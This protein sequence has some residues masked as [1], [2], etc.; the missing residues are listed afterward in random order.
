MSETLSVP[1][2][3]GRVR[4]DAGSYFLALMRDEPTGFEYGEVSSS[5]Q[6]L[7]TMWREPE[8]TLEIDDQSRAEQGALQ[9]RAGALAV[10]ASYVPSPLPPT[11]I[12]AGNLAE[13]V[14]AVS[15]LTWREIADVF[16][17]SERAVAGWR[18]QGV[19]RHR[20]ETMQALRAIGATLVGGLGPRGVSEW[21]LAGSPSSRLQRVRDGEAEAVSTEALSYLDSPAT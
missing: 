3:T 10:D 4:L 8:L 12:L 21:L 5:W 9:S 7:M 16:R 1:G 2:V 11:P 13:D 19:P 14:H 6:I 18:R 20:V 15:G 17:I